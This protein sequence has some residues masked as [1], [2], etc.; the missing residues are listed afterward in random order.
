[1]DTRDTQGVAVGSIRG[2]DGRGMQPTMTDTTTVTRTI[3]I[4]ALPCSFSRPAIRHAC[5]SLLTA[6]PR[7]IHPNDQTRALLIEPSL[8]RMARLS[9]S[10]WR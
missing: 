10:L 4:R 9:L 2:A 7:C 1:M 3:R 6:R 5:R 8:T